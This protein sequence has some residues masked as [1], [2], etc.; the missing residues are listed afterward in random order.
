M[1]NYAK[2]SMRTFG[3]ATL[4]MTLALLVGCGGP[5]SDIGKQGDPKPEY[6]EQV[7]A[8]AASGVMVTCDKTG[9]VSFLDFHAHPDVSGAVL[10]VREFPNLRLLNFSSSKLTDEDLVHLAAAKNVE[11]LGLHGTQVTDEGIQHLAGMTKLRQLNL[12]DTAVT[13]VTLEKLKMFGSL[14]RIDLQN[15]KVTDEGLKHL[16]DLKDLVYVQVSATDVTDDGV[17][18][19]Q[20]A[21]PDAQILNEEIDYS[22]GTPMMTD[23]ELPDN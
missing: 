9:E 6:A 8:A 19:L 16:A 23:A 20:V 4:T 14:V 1:K 5:E 2:T 22:G 17:N 15:T 21:L 10:H 12:T 3:L 11:E 18:Q 13:D 7:K